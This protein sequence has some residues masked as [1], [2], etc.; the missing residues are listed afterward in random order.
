MKYLV[1]I[2]FVLVTGCAATSVPPATP[3]GFFMGVWH[4]L[5]APISLLWSLIDS[6]VVVFSKNNTGT[7]YTVGFVIG[8]LHWIGGGGVASSR[9]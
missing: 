5:I 8:V 7:G 4:G 6:S 3:D 2:L 9:D 1:L